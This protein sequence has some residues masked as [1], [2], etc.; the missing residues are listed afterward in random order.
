[1]CICTRVLLRLGWFTL[2]ICTQIRTLV[3]MIINFKPLYFEETFPK[4]LDYFGQ[5]NLLQWAKLM[6]MCLSPLYIIICK[7]IVGS[8]FHLI[9]ICIIIFAIR[10]H[11]WY[12][13]HI[14]Y[15]YS[16]FSDIQDCFHALM[17]ITI[18]IS[19]PLKDT[20]KIKDTCDS[21]YYAP[22]LCITH[23][24][25]YYAFYYSTKF[26]ITQGSNTSYKLV[27]SLE[28]RESSQTLQKS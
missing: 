2:C 16:P 13:I 20:C 12:I 9:C 5:R 1:M 28:M 15:Y 4:I 24:S 10:I 18:L 23:I 14:Q 27:I 8:G 11:K 7:V 22:T 21:P 26:K 6:L 17:C 25:L 19:P 3:Q